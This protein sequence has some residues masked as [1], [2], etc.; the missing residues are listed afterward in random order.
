MKKYYLIF[1]YSIITLVLLNQIWLPKGIILSFDY[2]L[3]HPIEFRVLY[4]EN[5][6]DDWS[7]V[8]AIKHKVIN[9]EGKAKIFI[10]ATHLERLRI[11]FGH[12]PTHVVISNALLQG[13][14]AVVLGSKDADFR[15]KNI[16][17]KNEKEGEIRVASEHH[18]PIIVYNK[19]LS[20]QTDGSRKFN[21]F[22]FFLVLLTPG[23]L[24]YVVKE[25]KKDTKSKE[26][27]KQ[28]LIKNIEFLRIVFTIGVLICHFRDTLYGIW[29]GGYFGVEFFFILS[30]YLLALTF[31]KDRAILA[32]AKRNWIRF[33]PLIIISCILCGGGWNSFLGVL[34]LQDTGLAMYHIDDPPSWYI[35]VL[36][37][38]TLFYL[39]FLKSYT[40][41]KRNFLI[42]VLVFVTYLLRARQHTPTWLMLDEYVSKDLLRGIAGMGA[43]ILL[44]EICRRPSETILSS[45]KEKF[46]YGIAETML[47]LYFVSIFFS[48]EYFI[49]HWI[50]QPILAGILL[51][52]FIQKKGFVSSFL[53]KEIFARGAKYCLSIYLTHWILFV[54][55]FWEIKG[56]IALSVTISTILSIFLGVLFYYL[57]EK[58]FVKLLTP[59]FFKKQN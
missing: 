37:W 3:H 21:L 38:C 36:F 58:P 28:P 7:S 26:K 30:G 14:N 6:S 23:Y 25:I 35:A 20:V 40:G 9:K 11:D 15:S 8:K 5:E 46:F 41:D 34:M 50:V 42:G 44:S 55:R 54:H 16:E 47:L 22:N 19:P 59:L 33:V 24:L 12:K 27:R 53:E 31:R 48:K 2:K 52:L 51:C 57:I 43:G 29:S 10:P 56:N 13:E 39:G 18:N 45:I 17:V 1:L 49:D 4:A 32:I